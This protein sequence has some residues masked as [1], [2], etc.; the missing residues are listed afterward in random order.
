MEEEAWGYSGSVITNRQ[1]SHSERTSRGCCGSPGPLKIE[2]AQLACHVHH[3][4]DE[5]QAGDS[6]RFHGL[7]GK[8]ARIDAAS[9][10]FGF[11]VAFGARGRNLP[12]VKLL[13]EH[14]ERCIGK[15]FRLV[16][17]EPRFRKTI[18]QE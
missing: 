3:F 11:D 17:V 12:S 13:F 14:V 7:A 16:C 9:C 5:E 15:R 1:Y 8:F 2:A 4:A 6:L 18:R 10:H